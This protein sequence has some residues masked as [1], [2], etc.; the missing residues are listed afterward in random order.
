MEN[1]TG[2]EQIQLEVS[3]PHISGMFY[4]SSISVAMDAQ[5]NPKL[6]AKTWANEF[7]NFGL[8]LNLQIGDTHYHLSLSG[9]ESS[10]PTLS[11][12]ATT[13]TKHI[14]NVEV[15]T[16]SF[17]GLQQYKYPGMPRH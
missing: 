2:E 7:V 11:L 5:V 4:F 9:S 3:R 13:K 6:Q 15:W 12:E 10:M 17:Q 1:L 16:S 8:L 14:L